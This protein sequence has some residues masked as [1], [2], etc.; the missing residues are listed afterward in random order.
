M[1]KNNFN[2]Q[3]ALLNLRFLT[4]LGVV[5]TAVFLAVPVAQ[6][7][8]ANLPNAANSVA[9]SKRPVANSKQ[10]WRSTGGPQGGDGLAWLQL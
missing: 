3:L 5:I 4:P 7:V 9:P 10:F 2:S 1:M 8:G 6:V